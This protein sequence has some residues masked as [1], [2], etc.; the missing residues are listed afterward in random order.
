MVDLLIVLRL[1]YQCVPLRTRLR[2]LVWGI[3]LGV[4]LV[5]WVVVSGYWTGALP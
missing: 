4:A 3:V 5:G 1:D 2:R